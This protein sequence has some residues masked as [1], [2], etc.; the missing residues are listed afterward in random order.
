MSSGQADIKTP[1]RLSSC[2][3]RLKAP[4]FN[5]YSEKN[6]SSM[7]SGISSVLLRYDP[8]TQ[9]L[10]LPATPVY[11]HTPPFAHIVVVPASSDKITVLKLPSGGGFPGGQV[12]LRFSLAQC[13]LVP[14][15]TTSG[16]EEPC[17]ISRC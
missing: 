13:S 9:P 11:A 4:S 3:F 7:V 1:I 17:F 8:E 6:G 12:S 15:F 2:P 16:P 14:N 10:A 5:T